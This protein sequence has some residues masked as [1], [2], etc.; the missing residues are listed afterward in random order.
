[1]SKKRSI[2]INCQKCNK[3][4]EIT[5]YDSINVDIDPDLREEFLSNRIYFHKC[6]H[7]GEIHFFPMPVLYHDMTHKFMVQGGSLIDAYDFYNMSLKMN[8]EF[9]QMAQITKVG[10]TNIRDSVEK[11]VALENGLDHRVVTIYR[12]LESMR[13]VSYAKEHNFPKLC[14]SYLC[15]DDDKDIAIFLELENGEQE[16]TIS[17][18]INMEEYRKVEEEVKKLGL[19]DGSCPFMFNDEYA[20]LL[21]KYSQES[22]TLYRKLTPEIAIFK[23]KKGAPFF[24][25][26]PVFNE[27]LYKDND[28]VICSDGNRI[29][30][31]TIYKVINDMTIYEMPFDYKNAPYILKKQSKNGLETSENSNTLLDNKDFLDA[32][33]KFDEKR[34]DFP[35]DL[36]RNSSAI[37]GMTAKLFRNG[38][39]QNALTY[40]NKNKNYL[41][42]YLDQSNVPEEYNGNIVSNLVFKFED[43]VSYAINEPQKYAGILINPD[44]DNIVLETANLVNLY[45]P[46][47]ILT[48][49]ERTINVLQNI[50]EKEIE[51]IG[52]DNYKYIAMVYFEN[53]NPKEI[54][55]EVNL[56]SEVIGRGLTEG[57]KRL[58]E[59]ITC[60]Y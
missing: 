16:K 49:D 27:R 5:I 59:I 25:K 23:P 42:V 24:A 18:K 38:I 28:M 53:K 40:T 56:G 11:V 12:I 45:L 3:E 47:R 17:K 41:C 19:L 60:N 4:F 14:S 36:E 13:Y 2:K 46:D 54:S 44:K 7:C 48:N 35:Y 52:E 22:R 10:T 8:D 58:R 21:I 57:Y 51:Y 37:L 1:M 31:G 43:I 34:K 29:M 6:P 30:E 20:K 26:I 32:L 39:Q 33:I 15:Y 50:N 55:K 9:S